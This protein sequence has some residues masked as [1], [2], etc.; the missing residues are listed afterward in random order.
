MNSY[1]SGIFTRKYYE[2]GLVELP[3]RNIVDMNEIATDATRAVGGNRY[4]NG[5]GG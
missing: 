1:A 5:V 2:F 3:G 4:L